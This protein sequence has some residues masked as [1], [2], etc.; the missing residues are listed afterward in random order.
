MNVE[1]CTT[2]ANSDSQICSMTTEQHKND[3]SND[4]DKPLSSK[5]DQPTTKYN[6]AT[7]VSSVNEQKKFSEKPNDVNDLDTHEHDSC[8]SSES[9]FC[10]SNGSEKSSCGHKHK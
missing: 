2:D 7:T 6:E 3:A 1:I 8:S 10:H 9:S 4:A 5:D